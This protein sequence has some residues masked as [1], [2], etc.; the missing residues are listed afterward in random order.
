LIILQ[1]IVEVDENV[2]YTTA[3]IQLVFTAYQDIQRKK[4]NQNHSQRFVESTNA[5]VEAVSMRIIPVWVHHQ[6][7][8]RNR[9]ATY[10]LLDSCSQGSFVQ[11]SQLNQ[12]HVTGT[13]ISITV[14]TWN[15]EET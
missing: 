14:K 4:K 5:L 2:T 12:L 3:R 9:V 13:P 15:G 11:K 6:S 10:A 7:H 1:E 8:P